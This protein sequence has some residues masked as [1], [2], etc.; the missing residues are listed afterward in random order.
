MC[1]FGSRLLRSRRLPSHPEPFHT[2]VV[3]LV[4]SHERCFPSLS[5]L[6]SHREMMTLKSLKKG[7]DGCWSG[8]PI[9]VERHKGGCVAL[10]LGRVAQRSCGGQMAV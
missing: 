6:K 1:G 7:L 8:F 10:S 2:V 5:P 3:P 4:C 9:L